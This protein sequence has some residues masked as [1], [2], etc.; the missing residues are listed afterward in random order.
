[1]SVVPVYHDRS[2]RPR[3]RSSRTFPAGFGFLRESGIIGLAAY[4]YFFVRGLIH[5]RESEAMDNAN[6]LVSF[7]RSLGIF[8]ER[9]LQSLI[10]G[11]HW[12]VTLFNWVY[13]Y[14]HWPVVIGTLAWLF[15]RHREVFPVFRSAM[16]ISG[17]IGF[18]FFFLFPMAPPRL[19][20]GL[21]FVDT[22]TLHS[23]AYRVLQPPSLTNPFAAMPSLHVGW[24]LLMGIAIVSFASNRFWKVFGVLMPIAMYAATILTGNHYFLDGIV[25]SALALTGLALAWKISGPKQPVWSVSPRALTPAMR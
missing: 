11:H 8:Q 10:L 4:L 12:L 5:A 22:V 15:V 25:G 2:H 7:E 20:D 6:S 9:E 18:V 24:N 3:S 21:G 19:V 23:E 14:G 16:V 13:I 17:M 1:M